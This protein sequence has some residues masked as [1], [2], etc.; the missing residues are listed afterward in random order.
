MGC[1]A[2]SQQGRKRMIVQCD[3]DLALQAARRIR[4]RLKAAR[5]ASPRG[6]TQGSFTAVCSLDGIPREEAPQ[7]NGSSSLST[8]TSCTSTISSISQ[9]SEST[10][11]SLPSP[12]SFMDDT[13]LAEEF[14]FRP[15]DGLDI[16]VKSVATFRT[17]PQRH[18]QHP[19]VPIIKQRSCSTEELRQLVLCAQMGLPGRAALPTSSGATSATRTVSDVC[20]S[21]ASS[22]LAPAPCGHGALD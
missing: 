8:S 12:P 3:H 14:G 10:G 20:L 15:N 6:F 17:I 7:Q 11:S 13:D 4:D 22:D 16:S 2:S 21:P 5:A 19:D 1:G 9:A 18:D